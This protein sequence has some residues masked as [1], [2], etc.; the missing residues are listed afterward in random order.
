MILVSARFKGLKGIYSKS[1]KT[2]IYIDFTKCK[3]KTIYIVGKNGSGKSTLMSV[4]HPFPDA[5]SM[6]LDGEQ[7]EKEIVYFHEGIYYTILILYP[8]YANKTRAVSKAYLKESS[9]TGTIELNPNGTIGS[10]KEALYDKFE[11]DPN[12]ITLSYLS[13]EDRGLVDKRPADRKKSI[14][15]LLESIQVYNDIYSKLTKK[16]RTLKTMLTNITNKINSIG[17]PEKLQ[18]QQVALDQR[19]EKLSIEKLQMEKNISS[20]EATIKLLDPDGTL[21]TSYKNLVNELSK[22]NDQLKILS[23]GI[24]ENLNIDTVSKNYLDTKEYKIRISKDLEMINRDVDNLLISRDEDAKRITIKTEKINNI[25]NTS[26]ISDIKSSIT[27]YRK[28]IFTYEEAFK[29]IGIDKNTTLSTEEYSTALNVMEDMRTY[30]TNIKSYATLDSISKACDYIIA[31][32]SPSSDLL[33]CGENNKSTEAAIAELREKLSYYKAL[34]EKT[35]I[36]SNRPEGCTDDTC[37]FIKDAINA[38][39]LNPQGH[40]DELDSQLQVLN[41]T[42]IEQRYQEEYLRTVNKVYMDLSI[43]L[44]SIKINSV[45]LRKVPVGRDLI[46]EQNLIARVK[47]GDTF[48]DIYSIY[49]YIEYANIF[50][51]YSN[52]KK[53]LDNLENQYK[54][55][56]TQEATIDDMQKEINELVQSTNDIDEK[57]QELNNKALSI[58]KN[59]IDTDAKLNQINQVIERLRKIN[60]CK[61][62]KA[63]IESKLNIINTNIQKISG[64]IEVINKSRSRLN[65]VLSELNPIV[66]QKEKIKFQCAKLVEY[67]TEWDQYNSQYNIVEL[68]KKYSTPTRGGIQTIFMQLYMDKT[69]SMSN[70]LLRMMFGGELELLPYVINET[71]FRIPIRNLTTNLTTDDVSNCSTSEKCMIAMIMGFILAFQGSTKYNIVRLDEIDGGLDQYNRSIFPQILNNIMGIL[72]INQ[73]FIVSH[74][75]ESDM[76]DVDIISLTPVSHETLRGNVIFQL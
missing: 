35:T 47:N 42:L 45:I 9:P 41:D 27:E 7:G 37:N 20:A 69:L 23:S 39:K 49:K 68:L 50:N 8:V 25:L 43:A 16:S 53:V 44:R 30:I 18:A 38:A 76:S 61:S 74:S 33:S 14:A 2:E 3:H 19:F 48:N 62:D 66:D 73:C 17:D 60:Q 29:K 5:P 1:G 15:D 54:L 46:N 56:K 28:K 65:A 72:N 75:S 12:F 11:L 32:T 26:N 22:V 34:L 40:I 36:L 59:I 13:T 52:D 70:Q 64:E 51:L 10:F 71:E 21:Q 6:Y 67:R 63:D 58:Q 57:V 24:E 31:N 4:L 55:F